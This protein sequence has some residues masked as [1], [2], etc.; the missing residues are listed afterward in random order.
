MVFY[1]L[2]IARS[3]SRSAVSA[4]P[5]PQQQHLSAPAGSHQHQR[6]RTT[7]QCLLQKTMSAIDACDAAAAR[8]ALSQIE[9]ALD[10]RCGTVTRTRTD[11]TS[12]EKKLIGGYTY[13][14]KFLLDAVLMCD[15]L[16]EPSMLTTAMLH[17]CRMLMRPVMFQHFK[18]ELMQSRLPQAPC[19]YDA[20]ITF[21]MCSMLWAREHLLSLKADRA[22]PWVLH[23]R[24]DSSP[25]FGR[26][27][28]VL[29]ADY[30]QYGIDAASTVIQKRLLPIQC[31]GSRAGSEAHKLDKLL[32]S[33]TLESEQVGV[34]VGRV[35]ECL[36]VPALCVGVRG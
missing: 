32:H 24:C 17:S 10:A 29:Q 23:L 1:R 6:H 9:S 21:D 33:L 16:T 8:R 4:V 13:L 25:Q 26:D 5:S 7:V 15:T 2:N 36:C 22:K 19:L 11:P 35:A 28:L 18:Q 30:I 3:D 27:Y 14:P 12:G 31:V 20:R 34:V